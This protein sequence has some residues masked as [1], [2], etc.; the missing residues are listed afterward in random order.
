MK[1]K[2]L[3]RRD[4]LFKS[5]ALGSLTLIPGLTIDAALAAWRQSEQIPR[6]PTTWDEIGPF[7]KRGAPQPAQLRRAGDL[8]F[9][10]SVSGKVFDTR[11]NI[12]TDAR[13]EIWQTN[14]QGI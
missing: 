11:G 6:K 5:A 8:G 4:L 10:I 7:Y 1:S 9:P 3:T 2:R 13:I 14:H 12:L